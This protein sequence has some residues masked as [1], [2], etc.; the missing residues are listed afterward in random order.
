MIVSCSSPA[1]LPRGIFGGCLQYR[2]VLLLWIAR[3]ENST[4]SL[5]GT[6]MGKNFG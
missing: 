5:C 4:L 2:V 1:Q 3:M 6:P